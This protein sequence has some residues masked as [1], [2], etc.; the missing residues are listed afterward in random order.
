MQKHIYNKLVR[1]GIVESIK[2]KGGQVEFDILED[3]SYAHALGEKLLEESQ[4][5]L[6]AKTPTAVCEEIADVLEVLHA[7]A[8]LHNLTWSG[9]EKTNTEKRVAKGGFAKRIFLHSVVD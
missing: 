7:I 4:E 6:K 8:Q 2:A 5:L 9:V 3:A 1:D